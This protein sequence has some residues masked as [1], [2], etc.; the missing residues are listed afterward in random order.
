MALNNKNQKCK[1]GRSR[2]KAGT[3]FKMRLLALGRDAVLQRHLL[4]KPRQ[5]EE[6]EEAAVLLM[7]LS[8]GLV[9]A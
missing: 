7:T 4:Q 8:C 5:L 1:R 2:I 6:D 3:S 9:N